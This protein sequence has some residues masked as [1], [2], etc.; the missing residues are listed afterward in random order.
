MA[1]AKTENVKQLREK[2][3]QHFGF[4][5]FRP[6]QAVAV[7]LAMEGIDTLIVMPT[8]SGKSLCF[9]LPGLEREGLTLVVS[10]LI[11]LMKDQAD[12]L[13]ELGISVAT[14]NSTLSDEQY[15]EAMVA[16][17]KGMLDFVYTTPE[18][19]SDADFRAALRQQPVGLFVIDEAHCV[20]Q[21]GH[22]FRPDY[23]LLRDGISHLG[24]PPVMA[25]TATATPEVTDDILNL[26]QI[27]EATVIH[28]GF[29]RPNLH[30]SVQ[31][32]E[33]EEA[34]LRWLL[35]FLYRVEGTGI[36][37]TTTVKAVTELTEILSE[38]GLSVESYHG[39]LNSKVR[40]ETQNRFLDNQFKAL[41]ATNAFGM[42]IDKPDIRFVIHYHIPGRI[43]S[44]YQEFG[45]GGRDGELAQG[46]LLYDPEDAK[47]Q[48]FFQTK[49]YPNDSDLVNAHH[50]LKRFSDKNEAPTFQELR[51]ISPLS[52][53]RLKVCLALF[54]NWEIVTCEDNGGYRLLN[55]DI[56]R[57]SLTHLSRNYRNREE[58]ERERHQ[59]MLNYAES[60]ECRWKRLLR[61][62]EEENEIEEDRCGHCDNCRKRLSE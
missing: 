13:R 56:A 20:S 19:L 24:H 57:E 39:R 44:F 40:A 45:R 38:K 34:K 29:Y 1:P 28:T 47:L 3:R 55:P 53:S 2:L 42:G 30:L 17:R 16:I 61:Y 14:V 31:H 59:Q 27:P 11:A 49:R 50:A 48:R 4:Q 18:Q 54:V 6:G 8:G 9:Q 12:S 22:D 62:F 43:E 5:K 60:Y 58:Q 46:I 51:A 7:H 26:L 41:I 21:W 36:I 25:L 10:P 33:G 32:Q 35:P 23:L 37:Y 15:E 52:K